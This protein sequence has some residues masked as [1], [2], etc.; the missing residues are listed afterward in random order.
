MSN[1]PW[2]S[3]AVY[4]LS[5]FGYKSL[6]ILFVSKSVSR[7]LYFNVNIALAKAVDNKWFKK[8]C[9]SLCLSEEMVCVKIEQRVFHW[10]ECCTNILP[11]NV[12]GKQFMFKAHFAVCDLERVILSDFLF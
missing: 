2:K 8:E 12:K 10:D 11:P 4:K 7:L 9:F 6:D 1:L 5:C 3:L